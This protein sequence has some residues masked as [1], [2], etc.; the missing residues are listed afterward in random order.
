M[1]G[2]DHTTNDKDRYNKRSI[3][4]RKLIL[5]L[6]ENYRNKLITLDK[7]LAHNANIKLYHE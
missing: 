2:G 5:S 1:I 7:D 6:K 4:D 3:V